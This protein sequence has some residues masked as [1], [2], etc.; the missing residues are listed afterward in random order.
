MTTKRL[1]FQ[2]C[3]SFETLDVGV[4]KEDCELDRDNFFEISARELAQASYIVNTTHLLRHLFACSIGGSATVYFHRKLNE[5]QICGREGYSK[6]EEE[7]ARQAAAKSKD[8]VSDCDPSSSS[9]SDDDEGECGD[10]YGA[11]S[12]YWGPYNAA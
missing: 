11:V 1:S 4:L 3:P 8:C 10:N 6:Q 12:G 2:R 9:G 5:G 7:M